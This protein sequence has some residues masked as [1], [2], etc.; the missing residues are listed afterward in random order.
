MLF[1][2]SL[3]IVITIS[4]FVSG[5]NSQ[6]C[7]EWVTDMQEATLANYTTWPGIQ[8]TLSSPRCGFNCTVSVQSKSLQAAGEPAFLENLLWPG[9]QL[10]LPSQ[11]R[12]LDSTIKVQSQIPNFAD[13]PALLDNTPWRLASITKTF[14]AVAI[15]KLSERGQLDLH[16]PAVQYLPSWAI[17]LLRQ[18]QGAVNAEKIST[19]HLLHHTSGLGD[20]ASD[21]RWLKE[22]L[23]SPQHKWT[24]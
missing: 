7:P 21:P 17:D 9:A 12:A 23:S 10:V 1:K 3:P 5:S 22:V 20:F 15:L 6:A 24:P 18:S 14:T 11:D 2:L 8:L 13:E 4:V 16:A 19:W